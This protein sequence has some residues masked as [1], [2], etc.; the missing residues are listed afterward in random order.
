MPMYQFEDPAYGRKL[1]GKK[2][3]QDMNDQKYTDLYDLFCGAQY[4]NGSD[5]ATLERD[6]VLHLFKIQHEP[7]N[8]WAESTIDSK[9]KLKGLNS[10][11]EKSDFDRSFN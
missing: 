10:T 8:T 2:D 4:S 11:Y 6:E 1:K 5:R 7:Q 3:T 9:S